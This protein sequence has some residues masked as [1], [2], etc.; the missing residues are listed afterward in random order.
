M[1]LVLVR[2]SCWVSVKTVRLPLPAKVE[3]LLSSWT[4]GISEGKLF[5]RELVRRD[6]S[7]FRFSCLKQ[8]FE[9]TTFCSPKITNNLR[10]QDVIYTINMTWELNYEC[11]LCRP[12]VY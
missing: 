2:V 12:I 7:D 6:K 11:V 5:S 10:R 3:N 8:C 1:F 9:I 4:L